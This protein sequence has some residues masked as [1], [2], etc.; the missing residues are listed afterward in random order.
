MEK[1]PKIKIISLGETALNTIEKEIIAH[2][3]ISIITIKNNY[4]DLKIYF[5]NTDVIL[6]I[7]N[8]YFEN[9]KN[10]ALEIIRNTEKNDIFT[11]IY[12]IGNGYTDLF[13]S[14]T[15]FIIKCKSAEDLKNGINGITKTL[16][17]KGM[18]TLDL[19][20]LKT[21]FQKT[22]K[23]FVIFE[24]GNL[25]TFDDSLQNLKLKLET[26]DKNKTYKIFLNITAGKNIELTKIKNVAK[27]MSSI[28]KE[29]AFLWGLHIYP[30]NENFI[31]II[32]YIVEDSVK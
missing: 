22:S 18:V 4:K 15:N 21:V 27:I 8:A 20:D 25:E 9:D 29:W 11:G 12:D 31:N 5:Q 32:A 6:I 30:E 17:A 16:T 14:K 3:N 13:D 24:K 23:S 2:E 7:L 26:F 19:A 1:I 10:F 28:L